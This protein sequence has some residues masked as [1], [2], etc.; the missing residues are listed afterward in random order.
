MHGPLQTKML[1]HVAAPNDWPLISKNCKMDV[2]FIFRRKLSSVPKKQSVPK[3][4]KYNED[5]TL[6]M[7]SNKIAFDTPF[8][9]D[10]PL[11][12]FSCDQLQPYDGS[13]V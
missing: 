8:S 7:F 9:L 5:Q 3:S 12:D 13:H 11:Y 6:Q 2:S 4:V 1:L 10:N